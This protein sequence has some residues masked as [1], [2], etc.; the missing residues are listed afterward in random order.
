VQAGIR[1]SGY[2]F[3]LPAR[4]RVACLHTSRIE[5]VHKLPESDQLSGSCRKPRKVI[6]Q[7]VRELLDIQP[8]S[9]RVI[10]HI[11]PTWCCSHYDDAPVMAVLPLRPI[12][13]SIATAGTRPLF[14]GKHTI[15]ISKYGMAV[16]SF[17]GMQL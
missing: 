13:K 5:V 3:F 1:K 14:Q 8:A 12:P 6:G 15:I 16:F 17:F 4:A 11:Q 10:R 7:K 9:I 2:R